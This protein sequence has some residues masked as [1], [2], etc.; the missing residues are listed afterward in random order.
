M[1]SYVLGT[2]VVHNSGLASD[3]GAVWVEGGR[4]SINVRESLQGSTDLKR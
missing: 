1:M 4:A 2:G 3:R